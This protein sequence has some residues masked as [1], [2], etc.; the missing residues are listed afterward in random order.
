MANTVNVGSTAYYL[1]KY[2]ISADVLAILPLQVGR[3][4]GSP[5]RDERKAAQVQATTNGGVKPLRDGRKEIEY[6]ITDGNGNWAHGVTL[7]EAREDL[8][9]KVTDR[10]KSDYEHL[11]LADTLTHAE[12]I[13]CYRVVTGACSRGTRSFIENRLQERKESYSIREIISLTE[14][15]YGNSDFKKFFTGKQKGL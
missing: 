1:C 7:E 3:W 8:V 9:Y 11:T 6:L 15:E 14:G 10:K 4:Y 2:A 12:A 13:R 5:D